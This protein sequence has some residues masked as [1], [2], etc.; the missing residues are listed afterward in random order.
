MRLTRSL[1]FHTRIEPQNA[2]LFKSEVPGDIVRNIQRT[3]PI[4]RPPITN[5]NLRTS[6]VARIGYDQHRS[7]RERTVGRDVRLL[8]SVAGCDHWFGLR[9]ERT[10]QDKKSSSAHARHED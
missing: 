3:P 6:A 2:A 8:R 5:D 1:L 9:A 4:E 7:Q 10:E